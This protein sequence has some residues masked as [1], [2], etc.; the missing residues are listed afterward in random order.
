MTYDHRPGNLEAAGA[1]PA[2]G[3][4]SW[5]LS[6]GLAAALALSAFALYGMV[7]ERV[8]AHGTTVTVTQQSAPPVGLPRGR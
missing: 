3:A 4:M 7:S 8:V 5:G 2:R 6:L 1:S